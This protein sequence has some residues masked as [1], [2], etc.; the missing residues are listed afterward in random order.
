[1]S[2]NFGHV[3]FCDQQSIKKKIVGN[4]LH[5]SVLRSASEKEIRSCCTPRFTIVIVFAFVFARL[6]NVTD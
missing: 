2:H 4:V 5:P 6:D 1:M 3:T